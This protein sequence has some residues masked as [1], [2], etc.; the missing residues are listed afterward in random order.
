MN[1]LAP[2]P[3]IRSSLIALLAG[4]AGSVFIPGGLAAQDA[5]PFP[6][7]PPPPMEERPI[8]FPPYEETRLGNGLRVV[9][10]PYGTQPVMSARL[11]LPGGNSADPPE[12]EGLAELTATVLTRGTESRSAEAISARIEGVGGSLSATAGSDFLTVSVTTLADDAETGFELLGDVLLRATFPPDEVELARTQF[13]S[14]LQAQQGQPQTI[15]RRHLAELLFGESHPYG[16]DATPASVR[17]LSREAVLDYR[18]RVIRPEGALLL[19]AGA[20]S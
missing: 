12:L 7:E 19:V 8:A 10:L 14:G 3:L 5:P 17:A 13:L 1:R 18:E 20:L 4:I 2:L 6:T 15:A 9:A 16:V 11:Y